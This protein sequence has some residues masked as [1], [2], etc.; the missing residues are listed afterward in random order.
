MKPTPAGWPRLS[1]AIYYEDAKAA[2]DWLCKAF[3]FEVRILVE[4][5]EDQGGGVLHSELVYGDAV[6][7][8]ASARPDASPRFGV[9]MRS[10]IAVGAANTQNLMLYV[11]DAI[12]HCEQARAAGAMITAEPEVHDY[13]DEY[14]ADRSYGCIDTEGHLWWFS[15][16]VRG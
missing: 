7:M 1:S 9:P 4:A 13:G 16:R 3:G 6:V 2:I 15:E 10:P 12:A 11:D 8:I 14:W 5:P